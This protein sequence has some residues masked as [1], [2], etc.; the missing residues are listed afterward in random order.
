LPRLTP[1]LAYVR[2]VE[3]TMTQAA[4][5]HRETLLTTAITILTRTACCET[6]GCRRSLW[7]ASPLHIMYGLPCAP[8]GAWERG[9][10]AKLCE[11]KS[12]QAGSKT[13]LLATLLFNVP[14]H[15]GLRR[16]HAGRSRTRR[17][18]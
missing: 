9:P 14:S 16:S 10:I 11:G 7:P 8:C 3:G 2:R 18:V 4:R 12:E 5:S 17:R 13:A 1:T 15:Y 6:T